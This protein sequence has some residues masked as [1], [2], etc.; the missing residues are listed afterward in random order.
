MN[1]SDLSFILISILFLYLF[2]DLDYFIHYVWPDRAG[3]TGTIVLY[4]SW[5]LE[6][7]ST[8]PPL[9]MS[10]FSNKTNKKPCP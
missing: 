1:L 6:T 2:C 3:S 7:D 4:K 9:K 5:R 10:P 8:L